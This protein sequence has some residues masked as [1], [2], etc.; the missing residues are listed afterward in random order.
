MDTVKG[1]RARIQE[2]RACVGL[3][4]LGYAGLPLA[5]AFAEVGFRVVGYERDRSR[6]ERLRDGDSYI[7]DVD[8]AMLARLLGAGRLEVASDPEVLRSADAIVVCVPTPLDGDGRPDTSFLQSA[9]RDAASHMRR[10]ALLVIESTSYPGTTEEIVGPALAGRGLRVGRD[11]FLAFS[12]E[13]VDPGNRGWGVRDIPKIVGGVDSESLEL[14]AL[15]YEHVAPK[16]VPV[17]SAAAAE[18]AKLV[19]NVFREVNIALANEVAQA[20][21][22]LGLD[23]WEVIDAAATK[24]FGFMPFYP[25]PGR[26]GH[27]IPSDPLFLDWKLRRHGFESKLIGAARE[28]NESMPCYVADRVARALGEWGIPIAGATVL[29]L[30]V[31]YKR[32]V[33]DTRDSP[34][35][36]LIDNL[37]GLG[38]RVSYHDPYVPSLHV[39]GAELRCRDLEAGLAEADCVIVAADHSAYDWDQITARARYLFDCRGA[40]RDRPAENVTRL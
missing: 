30:G 33:P 39:D 9:V 7:P 38:A 40:L 23:A 31:T 2:R 25:G 37:A 34:V 26:G 12:P 18:M 36:R 32:D 8:D 21:E 4:G 27:C 17:S 10:G 5:V 35:K 22:L 6:S 19:E 1:L 13:R 15:L 3:M 29:V 28:V 24:P 14:A 20:C 11:V 16:V